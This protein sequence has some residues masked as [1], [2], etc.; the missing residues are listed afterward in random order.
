MEYYLA[1]KKNTDAC[2]MWKNLKNVLSSK[3]KPI[4]MSIIGKSIEKVRLVVARMWVE[5]GSG[6]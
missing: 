6:K 1:I 4:Q 2:S 3:S 5:G